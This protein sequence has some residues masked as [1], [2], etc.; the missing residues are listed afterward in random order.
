MSDDQSKRPSSYPTLNFDDFV[1]FLK[2]HTSDLSCQSCG[3]D[4]WTISTADGVLVN[5]AVQP[6]STQHDMVFLTAPIICNKCGF[7]RHYSY[8]VI[9]EA[10][11]R[12][13]SQ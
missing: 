1:S 12:R 4:S 10:L 5:M 7:V 3:T 6:F 13:N 2:S 9:Q 11:E 8:Q